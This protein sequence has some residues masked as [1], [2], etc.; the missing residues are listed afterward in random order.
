MKRFLIVIVGVIFLAV[1]VFMFYK[2]K[3]LTEKCTEETVATVVDMKQ[4][5]SGDGDSSS[6]LYYPIIEYLAN[7]DN[8]RVTMDKGSNV[9]AYEI[10]DTI[11]ILYNPSKVKEFIVKGDKS[12]NIFSI[13]FLGIGA[14]LC[15]YGTY[16]LIKKD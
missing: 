4:E 12:L 8:V 11:T 7:E 16:T 15:G 14:L 2:N 9:P 6:Y 3:K 5:F 13:V 1:S 10:D